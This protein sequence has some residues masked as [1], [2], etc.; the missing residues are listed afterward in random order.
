[1]KH[2][3]A[4]NPSTLVLSVVAGLLLA[5]C[6]GGSGSGST[7]TATPAVTVTPPATT[8]AL[9]VANGANVVEF[10]P[11][12]LAPGMNATVPHLSN[13]SGV[14]VAP[15]GVVF[16]KAGHLWVLDG[17]NAVAGGTSPAALYRFDPDQLAALGTVANPTPAVTIKSPD[18]KFPQQAVFDAQG[19][20]WMSDNGADAVFVLAAAQL[21][22]SSSSLAP[23]ATITSNAAF[24]GPL[25]IVF[26]Q[27][28]DL[29]VANNGT[30]TIFGFKAAHLPTMPGSF[31]L[32][33]DVVLSDDGMGSIQAP[34]ALVF[35]AAGNLWSSNA[36]PPNTV[37]EFSPMEIAQTGSPVPVVT[38]S[39]TVVNGQTTIAAPNGLAFDN[40]GDLAVISSATPFGVG[41][42]T[43]G[44]LDVTGAP[45]PRAFIVGAATTLNAPAGCNFGPVY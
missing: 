4:L 28:G 38:V 30:T 17:G 8:E 27:A 7:T 43:Q 44:Q 25:G 21:E 20:L 6:G 33:P 2:S 35:D 26:D 41:F 16:D 37:V 10:T 39:P 31:T 19:N 45:G 18:F 3:F 22:Q 12:Q 15:Q 32:V 34:W 1:M 13:N 5:G 36:N 11:A 40:L 24:N 29:Y 9:W 23:A 14:F 42:F